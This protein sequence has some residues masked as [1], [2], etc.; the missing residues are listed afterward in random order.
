MTKKQKQLNMYASKMRKK[1]VEYETKKFVLTDED[2]YMLKAHVIQVLPTGK[3]RRI[4]NDWIASFRKVYNCGIHELYTNLKKDKTYTPSE[5]EIR[6]KYVI[7]KRMS[8]QIKK[9]M[10]WTL[11]TPKRIREGA[12][13]DI[14]SSYKGCCTRKAKKQIKS[15]IMKPKDSNDS[16][17]TILIS[18]DSSYIKGG[19]LQTGG[20]KLRLNEKME[21]CSLEHNMRLTR[22]NGL[23]FICIPYSSPPEKEKKVCK[24]SH[25]VAVDPGWNIFS[26]YYSPQGEFGTIGTDL[27][28]R[29]FTFYA[30]EEKIKN[31]MKTSQKIKRPERA[32]KKICKRI[33]GMV[34][35]FQW[36]LCHWFLEHFKHIFIPRL[37]VSRTNKIGKRQQQDLKHC[38]FVDRLIHVSRLYPESRIYVCSERNTTKSCTKCLSMNTIRGKTIKCLSCGHEMHRD[39]SSSR[40]IFVLQTK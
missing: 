23:Y 27:K 13:K 21:D 38:Q 33:L 34:N 3:Q 28:E 6:D 30:K 20:L 22:L 16:R 24:T 11:R 15:F 17:Q 32:L 37:Y 40:T 12:I 2:K 10:E 8:P 29:L 36:K 7:A 35:D 9:K 5:I 31:D 14:V 4:L 39:I 18:S 26:S 25:F 19:M 1:G